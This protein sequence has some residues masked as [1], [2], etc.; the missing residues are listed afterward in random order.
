MTRAP[1]GGRWRTHVPVGSAAE[2]QFTVTDFPVRLCLAEG[3]HGTRGSHQIQRLS[4]RKVTG[5]T[6]GRRNLEKKQGS[7]F[8]ALLWAPKPLAK[9]VT[10]QPQSEVYPD[11]W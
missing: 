9:M 1:I 3:E 4:Q 6:Q 8:G 7:K 10:S 11:R 5:D 2:G